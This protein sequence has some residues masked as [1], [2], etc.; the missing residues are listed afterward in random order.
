MTSNVI[1]KIPSKKRKTTALSDIIIIYTKTFFTRNGPPSNIM[2]AVITQKSIKT[3][4]LEA[5][6]FV[7]TTNH[8]VFYK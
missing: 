2:T 8:G 4:L 3:F 1:D 5:I 6:N 7:F